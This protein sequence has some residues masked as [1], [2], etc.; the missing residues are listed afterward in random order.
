MSLVPLGY[1]ISRKEIERTIMENIRTRVVAMGYLADVALYQPPTVPNQTAY[2]AA[3]QAIVTAG[4]QVIEVFGVGSNEARGEKRVNKIFINLRQINPGSI[5]HW[6]ESLDPSVLPNT[7]Q[8]SFVA[9]S[10]S[11]LVY[12]IRTVTK[13]TEYDRICTQALMNGVTSSR[14][15]QGLAVILDNGTADTS[16]Y[17]MVRL[18]NSTDIRNDQFIERLYTFEVID[19]WID[20]WEVVPYQND[21]V[22]II[23]V[24]QDGEIDETTI[25][26][27]IIN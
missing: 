6:G 25:D 17:V 4:K 8:R 26:L 23:E 22:P 15:A 11:N 16:R 14:T 10:S 13:T 3:N 5:S 2:T 7:W 27:G 12:D 24:E 9:T 1:T 21:I 19:A 18:V 20:S